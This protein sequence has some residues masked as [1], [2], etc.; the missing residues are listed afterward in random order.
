MEIGAMAIKAPPM[1]AEEFEK[2]SLLRENANRRLELI[3][4]EVI[5]LVSNQ[6]SGRIALQI[7]HLIKSYLD[8][9][10]IGYATPPDSGYRVGA[11]RYLPDIGYV[12]KARQPIPSDEAYNPLAPDLAVEVISPTDE[13]GEVVAKTNGYVLAGTTVWL[14]YP[15]RKEI[16][17][18]VPGQ[19]IKKLGID[20]TLAGGAI[21]PGFTAKLADIF[22]GE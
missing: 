15:K 5:E 2:F 17:V 16:H 11:D 13:T 3:G 6:K 7:G 8:Q 1:T 20:D 12:S 4:G 9:H 21:L 19:P 22:A 18:Y 10:P 14:V